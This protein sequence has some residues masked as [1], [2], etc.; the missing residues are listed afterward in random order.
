M[1]K[2]K[3]VPVQVPWMI[4]PSHDFAGFVGHES[5]AVRIQMM[6][7][8]NARRYEQAIS[9]LELQ[10]GGD[11]PDEEFNKAGSVIIEVTFTPVFLF[12]IYANMNGYE[13]YDLSIVNPY[14]NGELSLADEWN[15]TDICP[16]PG[17]YEVVHSELKEA[18]GFTSSKVKHWVLRGH[19]SSID[20][21]AYS[22]EWKEIDW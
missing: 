10:Y 20:V 13:R 16:N 3:V 2:M 14:Y 11:I 22:F 19:D 18:Y 17:F 15:Q 6:C 12:N 5:E 1:N 9:K 8:Y 4:S 7:G 21:L